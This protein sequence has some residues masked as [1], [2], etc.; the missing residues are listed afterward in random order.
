MSSDGVTPSSVLPRIGVIGGGHLGRIHA[1]LLS[2]NSECELVGVADPSFDSRK[3]VQSQLSAATVEDY[4]N[5]D[6]M[7][8]GVVVAAPTFL[9]YEIGAWCLKRGL[10]VLMEKPMASTL[11][12]AVQLTHL[13]KANGC[14]LQVGHVERFN[15]AWQLAAPYFDRDTIRYIEVARE[16]TYSG[17]STDIGIVMDLMIHDI[18][19]ILSVVQSPIDSISAYGWSALGEHEDFA[20]A[21]LRFRNGSSASL[22]ASRLSPLPKRQ[23][24]IYSDGGLTEVDFASGTVSRTCAHEDV[25][26]GSRQA[27]RLPPEQ[28]AKVKDDLYS[29]WLHR[30]NERGD[31]SNAIECEHR[32]FLHAVRT[33]SGVTVSGDDGCRA[34]EIASRILDQ[35]ASNRPS[36]SIIPSAD[37]FGKTKAA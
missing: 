22:R 13:A 15:P 2:A 26:D 1:K 18:D 7:V 27:D 20:A 25:A 4:R 28:R 24:Q 8:D 33:G 10:H 14:T 17:R 29:K 30:S 11:S 34:I 12:E 9:H 37:R 6:S 19:L 36:R 16:G 21:S 23:M 31:S 5:W 3:L 35:V 32:E